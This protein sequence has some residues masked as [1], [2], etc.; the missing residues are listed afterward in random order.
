METLL[1]GLT[2]NMV[3]VFKNSFLF[4]GIKKKQK[5]MFEREYVVFKN[6]P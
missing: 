2:P 5:S 1:K 6:T 4:F 3:V